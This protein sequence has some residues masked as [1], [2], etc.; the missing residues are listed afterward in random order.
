MPDYPKYYLDFSL[1]PHFDHLPRPEQ[2]RVLLHFF[3]E[4]AKEKLPGL[5]RITCEYLGENDSWEGA[6]WCYYAEYQEDKLTPRTMEVEILDPGTAEHLDSFVATWVSDEHPGWE[7]NDGGY[8]QV[9][10]DLTHLTIK[11]EHNTVHKEITT[12][13]YT[14]IG[15]TDD[16]ATC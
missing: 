1:P 13:S 12:D 4:A 14:L 3:L 11:L 6:T 2:G 15:E 5:R 7:N 16:E 10:I 9:E 8:G